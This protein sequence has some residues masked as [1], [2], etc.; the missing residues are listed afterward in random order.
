MVTRR[1]EEAEEYERIEW[2]ERERARY[3]QGQPPSPYPPQG[4]SQSQQQAPY[5]ERS[6]EYDYNRPPPSTEQQQSYDYQPQ[7]EDV[8][9]SYYG[10]PSPPTTRSE[11]AQSENLERSYYEGPSP[12]A[13][14]SQYAPYEAPSYNRND[15]DQ[16]Q[17]RVD[18]YR[19][20]NMIGSNPPPYHTG[21]AEAYYE[22]G[23]S[24]GSSRPYNDNGSA[25]TAEEDRGFT[26]ALAGAAL[27]GYG[28]HKMHHGFLGALAGGVLGSKLQDHMKAKKEEEEHKLQE[29]HHPPPQESHDHKHHRR[30]SGSSSSSSDSGRS[31]GRPDFFAGN[32]SASSTE[33]SLDGIFDLVASCRSVDGRSKLSVIRL[34][35]CLTNDWGHL[36]WA[37]HGNF[38]ASAKDIRLTDGGHV[39][40]AKL[41][42]GSG[43]WKKQ[44]IYLDE[45]I[46]N[47][48]G[49]LR[50]LE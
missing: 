32:F 11:Y 45:R 17:N 6:F 41:G 40:V 10:R 47:D 15:Y 19:R 26:G 20:D 50:F 25:P 30:D 16:S 14:Q 33:I 2:E 43:G 38:V 31:H 27:G 23:T 28:G 3:Q 46:T 7:Y 21:T 48:N 24:F 13:P 35:E 9:R 4:Y 39:L 37:K 12:P 49:E 8:E 42:D 36:R 18:P 44:R 22:Q 1:N 5:P 29:A 34:N